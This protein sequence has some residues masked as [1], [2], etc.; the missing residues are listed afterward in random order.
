KGCKMK[1][2]D[3]AKREELTQMRQKQILDV[4]AS[5]FSEKG[6][7]RTQ[8]DEIADLASLGKGTVYRYFKDKKNLFLSVADKG[9]ESLKDLVLEA[10]AKEKEPLD[11]I[12]KAIETYLKFFEKRPDLI[13]IFL[14]EQS[15]F[16]KRIEMRYYQRYY[17]HVNK[18]EEIFKEAQTL[19]LIKKK[20][21]PR[22]A[23]ATLIDMLNS[24]IYTWQLTGKK[25]SL[26]ESFTVITDIY[27]T[28][29]LEQK[30]K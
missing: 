21:N 30:G 15:E 22:L 28:G 27:F 20:L 9:I 25:Y 11:K 12:K 5:V 1:I 10:M 4:A 6:F 24:F 13:R 8:V 14:H 23:I 29:I 18:V 19:G 17:E 2:T 7:A 26:S 16:Q 3:K